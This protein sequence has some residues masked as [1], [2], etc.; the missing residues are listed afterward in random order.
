VIYNIY[1]CLHRSTGH[2]RQ[3][4]NQTLAEVRGYD[5]NFRHLLADFDKFRAQIISADICIVS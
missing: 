2:F 3:N 4:E 5:V 1:A